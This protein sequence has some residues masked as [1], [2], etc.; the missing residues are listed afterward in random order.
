MQS[1]SP[2][3]QYTLAPMVQKLTA[4]VALSAADQAAVLALP[5]TS[6]TVGRGSYMVREGD[7]PKVSQ[8]LIEGF[9]FRH[10]I[11]GDGQRQIVSVHIAGDIVDLQN[12]LLAVSDHNVQTLSPAVIL[13]IPHHA[14]E[15]LADEHPRVGRAMW[16]DTLVEGSI[17]REWTANVGRRCARARTS[18]LLC[19]LGLRMERA[20]LGRR[21]SYRFPIT[22][23][24]LADALGLTPVHVNR[25]LR[26]LCAEGLAE[27][28]HQSIAIA[29]WNALVLVGDFSGDY[30]HF[31]GEAAN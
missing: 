6:R 24:E 27:K 19:E 15:A 23:D 12:A 1:P 17:Q 16:R 14:I 21:S 9:A 2:Q 26:S 4:G 29:D 28:R 10:K 31:A 25:M 11:V 3:R 5:F 18:H 7:R 20:G 22:Q 30:L 8:V 13:E